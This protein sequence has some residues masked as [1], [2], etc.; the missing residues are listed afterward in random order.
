[1]EIKKKFTNW[2]LAIV[3]QVIMVLV[4][5]F[6]CKET[7]EVVKEETVQK[8][9]SAIIIFTVG[10]VTA[11]GQ[12]LKQGDIIKAGSKIATGKKSSCELQLREHS[13][14]ILIQLK[15]NS[16][17]SIDEKSNLGDVRSNVNLGNALFKVNKPLKK[18]ESVRVAAPTFV[19]GVRGTEFSLDV[20]KNGDSRVS[21]VSGKVSAVHRIGELEDLPKEI[22]ENSQFIQDSISNLEASETVIEPGQKV[23]VT[24]KESNSILKN[25]QL[26]EAI[27]IAK[28]SGSDESGSDIASKI[29]KNIKAKFENKTEKTVIAPIVQK[30]DQKDFQKQIK[31]FEKLIVLEQAKLQDTA[32]TTSELKKINE[33]RKEAMIQKIEEITGKSSETLILNSGE[34]IKGVVFQEGKTFI[35]LTPEGRKEYQEEEVEGT[36]F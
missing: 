25:S 24:K 19:A 2:N 6:S 7:N 9:I 33:E 11:E 31:E 32:S 5:S 29:D 35:V 8:S 20:A 3:L 26:V 18:G 34:K 1:M 10:D 14:E 30:M 12:K 27:K 36:E 13:S 4:M 21:V 28:A 22:I 15:Q 17:F 16:E 23:V